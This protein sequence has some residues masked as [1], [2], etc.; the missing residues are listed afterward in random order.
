MTDQQFTEV[1]NDFKAIE[2]PTADEIQAILTAFLEFLIAKCENEKIDAIL[3]NIKD[4]VEDDRFG[5]IPFLI[6]FIKLKRQS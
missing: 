3:E 5:V 1:L 4:R 6:N 2:T